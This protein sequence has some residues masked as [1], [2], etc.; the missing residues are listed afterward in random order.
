MKRL[1]KINCINH[2]SYRKRE[3]SDMYVN[4][5]HVQTLFIT[6]GKGYEGYRYFLKLISSE[7]I[8]ISAADYYDLIDCDARR[9]RY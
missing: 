2:I 9:N 1:F 3:I 7:T 8:E 6:K 4:I 5:D